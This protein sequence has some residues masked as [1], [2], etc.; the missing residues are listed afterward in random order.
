M[1]TFSIS[2]PVIGLLVLKKIFYWVS[3]VTCIS[4]ETN[5]FYLGFHVYCVPS[6]KVFSNNYFGF[7]LTQLQILCVYAF[8]THSLKNEVSYHFIHFVY[9]FQVTNS[10]AYYFDMFVSILFICD[11]FW[12]IFFCFPCIYFLICFSYLFL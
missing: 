1:I 10:Y 6:C 4:L 9:I 3:L 5:L 8:L 7:L 11:F 12:F 2:W